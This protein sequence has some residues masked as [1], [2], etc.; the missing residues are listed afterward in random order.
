VNQT[1]CHVWRRIGPTSTPLFG[2]TSPDVNAGANPSFHPD[3][4]NIH[5]ALFCRHR[6]PIY[7]ERFC[8]GYLPRGSDPRSDPR[9]AIFTST[10]RNCSEYWTI[11]MKQKPSLAKLYLRVFLGA[12]PKTARTVG[13]RRPQFDHLHTSTAQTSTA[14]AYAKRWSCRK[15]HRASSAENR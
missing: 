11:T 15:S 4:G 12:S 5:L 1:Q 10:T 2:V 6:H 8:V 7:L 14:Q 3:A 9:S 13:G